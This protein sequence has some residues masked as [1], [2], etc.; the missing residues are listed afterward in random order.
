MNK[1]FKSKYKVHL[2][3]QRLVYALI[4]LLGAS[5][6][7][8]GDIDRDE[9][10]ESAK[11]YSLDR[12]REVVIERVDQRS[13]AYLQFFSNDLVF[14]KIEMW[15][16][17]LG[18]SPEASSKETFDCNY[19]GPTDQHLIR[20]ENLKNFDPYYFRILVGSG[21]DFKESTDA[22][23]FKEKG[24]N[25]SFFPP[26][27]YDSYVNENHTGTLVRAVL[28]LGQ[29]KAHSKKLSKKSMEAQKNAFMAIK[30]GC[31][32]GNRRSYTPLLPP[33]KNSVENISTSGHINATSEKTDTRFDAFTLKF[34]DK[35]PSNNDWKFKIRNQGKVGQVSAKAPPSFSYLKIRSGA[36]REISL[37]KPDLTVSSGSFQVSRASE[38]ALLWGQD[39]QDA[40]SYISVIIGKNSQG[41]TI[42][43]TFKASEG[44]ALIP[45]KLLSQLPD[46]DYD[47]L[48]T[49]N[50]KQAFN[51]SENHTL[52]VHTQDWRHKTLSIKRE[53]TQ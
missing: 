38:L 45:E 6:C 40:N 49:L 34:S 26:K 53:Q 51:T 3:A 19:S 48:V 32:M 30:Q 23:V 37:A 50:N 22:M 17:Y 13:T 21:K 43:C 33:T 11:R 7:W 31:A 42:K 18:D 10:K 27:N 9:Q 12:S 16:I 25:Y 44:S 39:Q 14:C 41:K 47:L 46:A 8:L 52:L 2:I 29:A 4:I 20:I 1:Y 36:G 28:P 5:S 24:S 35:I 15:P